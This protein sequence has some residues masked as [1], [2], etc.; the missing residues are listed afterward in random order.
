LA[1]L[2]WALSLTY[3]IPGMAA[4]FGPDPISQ[5]LGAST[6]EVLGRAAVRLV[7]AIA[8][9]TQFMQY[10]LLYGTIRASGLPEDFRPIP[11]LV[12]N[13]TSQL[14]LAAAGL[15]LLGV[16]FGLLPAATAAGDLI[17]PQLGYTSAILAFGLGLGVAFSPTDRRPAALAGMV[18][19]FIAFLLAAAFPSLAV[20]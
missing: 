3:L 9:W 6:I 19:G 8:A 11:Q 2:V 7:M 17:L 18:L 5:I 20:S 14:A 15:G 1:A 13:W 4:I 10:R 16:T 12:P